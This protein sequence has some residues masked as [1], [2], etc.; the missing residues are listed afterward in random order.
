MSESSHTPLGPGAEFDAIRRMLEQWGPLSAGIG[1]DAALLDVPAGAQLVVS[2]DTSVEGVHFR[3]DWMST[4]EIGCR[5]VIAAL[6]DLA[7]MGAEPLGVLVSLVVPGAWREMLPALADGIGKAVSR[8]QTRIVGG[9]LSAGAELNITST[10]LGHVRAPLRRDAM[11][12]GDALYVTG[13]LGAVGAALSAFQAGHKPTAAQRERFV[14]PIARLA[15]G[16]W[17]AAHGAHGAVDVSDGLVADAA[18]LAAA[19]TAGVELNLEAIPVADGV[20]PRAALV[21]GEEYE[22]LVAA[23]EPLDVSAFQ[24]R[25]GIA[26]T[27]IGKA[28]AQ[29][30]GEVVVLADGQRIAAGHGHDQFHA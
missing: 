20:T 24:A 9:N 5:A 28:V 7:A 13:Q 22:L 10:V 14:T 17:L 4:E 15:E 2:T 16:A 27:R 29:H 21:S 3:A 23:P 26:L 6:S 25:F 1:D 12:A 30:P 8:A 11:R 19:S 18:H